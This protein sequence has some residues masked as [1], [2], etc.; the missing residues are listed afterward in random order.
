MIG[1]AFGLGFIIGPVTGG[2][3]SQ[4][5]YDVPA[6]A[7]AGMAMLNLLLV[8]FWL[9]ESLT[10][11]K[12]AQMTQ[13]RPA[14]TLSALMEALKRPFTGSLLITRFFFGVAFAIFQTIFSL[15][16][17]TKFNLTAAQ[18]GY[19]LAYVGVLSVFTQGFLVGRLTQRVREDILI[20]SSVL[21]MG[22]SLVGWA[23]AAIAPQVLV[24]ADILW[25]ER[26]LVA[27]TILPMA[28]YLS[29]TDSL[30]IASGIWTINP[31]QSTGI[32][33]GALPLEEAVFFLITNVL[34]GF[35]MTLMLSDLSRQRLADWKARGFKGLP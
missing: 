17:L 8:F 34:I 5:G 14:V 28:V 16:A 3:L 23:L 25:H 7:A 35:G 13:K 29:A 18:T 9:P 22:L 31:A 32:F 12:R 6:F 11:E 1:A 10:D 20:V 19:V 4:W 21:V 27:L 26:K 30:A 24:G 2:V 15:Y 33:F